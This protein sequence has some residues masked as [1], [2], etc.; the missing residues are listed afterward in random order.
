VVG[1]KVPATKSGSF[2]EAGIAAVFLRPGSAAGSDGV[3]VRGKASSADSYDRGPGTGAAMFNNLERRRYLS[4]ANNTLASTRRG[5]HDGDFAAGESL[6]SNSC[7]TTSSRESPAC[8]A[9]SLRMPFSVPA[10][11]AA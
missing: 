8:S 6:Q 4:Q 5:I 10:R 9:T 2:A 1:Q 3:P 7:L 11:R